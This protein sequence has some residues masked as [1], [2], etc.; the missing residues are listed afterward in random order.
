MRKIGILTFHYSINEGAMLQGLALMRVCQRLF[1]DAKVELINYEIPTT[2]KRDLK[3]CFSPP[4]TLIS[5]YSQ[6]ERYRR[7]NRFK[8]SYLGLNNN[9]YISS[10]YNESINYLGSQNYDTI[11]VGSDEVWKVVGGKKDRPFPNAYWLSPKLESKKVAY[12]ASANKTKLDA[13]SEK[14]RRIINKCLDDFDLIGVR[15]DFTYSLVESILP[16][17][18]NLHRV[19]DPTLIIDNDDLPK[20]KIDDKLKREGFNFSKPTV[21]INANS[22]IISDLS[23]EFFHQKGWQ[24]VG[25]T[26]YCRKADINLVG[27]LNPLE[28]ISVLSHCKFSVTDR[29]H[30]TIFS[31]RENV[32]FISVEISDNYN[33]TNASKLKNLLSDLN[34]ED[35]LLLSATNDFSEKRFIQHLERFVEESDLSEVD[36]KIRTLKSNS[37]EFLKKATML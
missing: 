2:G 3:N 18:N 23:T 7:L 12:A 29:F 4:R 34:M 22:S 24:V 27:K 33:K 31:L 35:N 25:I 37:L 21:V 17:T 32:P 36:N 28:W 5:I 16:N 14:D 10:D 9:K 26:K 6:L 30:G 20:L 8:D 11:I 13:L 15:D 1:K 19:A